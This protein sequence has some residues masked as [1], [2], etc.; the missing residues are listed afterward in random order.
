M[1]V[2]IGGMGSFP[3]AAATAD[4]ATDKAPAKEKEAEVKLD[5]WQEAFVTFKTGDA[6]KA[7]ALC[8][9]ALKGEPNNVRFLMLYARSLAAQGKN[10]PAEAT[11]RKAIALDP[12]SSAYRRQ[13]GDFYYRLRRFDAAK[14]CYQEALQRGGETAELSLQLLYCAVGLGDAGEA[15]RLAS[16]TVFNAFDEATPAY[17]FAKAAVAQMKKR[18]DEVKPLMQQAETLYGH[19]LFLQYGRDYFFLFASKP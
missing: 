12:N 5:P 18:P 19:D 13:F 7:A 1:A 3:A 11:F 14:P 2:G 15:E 8:E 4:K 9:A 6:E 17:Y 10:E 16:G